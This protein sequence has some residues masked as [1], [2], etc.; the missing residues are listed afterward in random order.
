MF[1]PAPLKS[2][3][4]KPVMRRL[5]EPADTVAYK[6]QLGLVPQLAAVDAEVSD[7]FGRA[8]AAG[9]VR[10]CTPTASQACVIAR[11]TALPLPYRSRAA[12]IVA[13]RVSA[14]VELEGISEVRARKN[15]F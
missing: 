2:S 15:A 5:L 12:W 11:S 8:V 6:I 13:R 14:N 4:V 3:L 7:G 10:G 9:T 1:V